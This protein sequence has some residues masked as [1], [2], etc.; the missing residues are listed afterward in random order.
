MI[1]TATII[2]WVVAI[3]R[4]IISIRGPMLL[5]RWSL[6]LTIVAT[7]VG[8]SATAWDTTFDRLTTP[9]I[10]VL[11]VEEA[12]VISVAGTFIY[13]LTLLYE[14]APPVGLLIIVASLTI[15]EIAIFVCWLVAPV[16]SKEVKSVYL[17]G[18][19]I[20][21]VQAFAF[22]FFATLMVELLASAVFTIRLTRTIHADDPTGK[23]G[24][25]L[26]AGSTAVGAA[27]FFL[28]TCL[29]FLRPDRS[30][31][32]LLSGVLRN[33]CALI[34][35]GVMAGAVV[36][37]GGPRWFSFRSRRRYAVRLRPLWSGITKLFPVVILDNHPKA[38]R[39]LMP[40][41]SL[42]R[43]IIEIH[44]GLDLLLVKDDTKS[45]KDIADQIVSPLT[46]EENGAR[47]LVSKILPP[48]SSEEEERNVLC[49]LADHCRQDALGKWSS[50]KIYFRN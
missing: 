32:A 1:I 29:V 36:M 46:Q 26:I 2:C 48:M 39:G 6:T 18:A 11:I 34:L 27:V 30:T 33:V 17:H 16:H 38:T 40:G 22:L 5:W 31:T 7:A 10:A 28:A 9:N 37:V 43:M 44:D 14:K 47:I 24:G 41:K 45:S 21:S 23:I 15:I 13:L 3:L 8:I 12:F 25:W 35:M 20:P 50:M 49:S 19:H 4:V 42:E